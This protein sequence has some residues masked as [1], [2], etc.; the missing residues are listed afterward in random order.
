MKS[1]TFTAP[2]R[3]ISNQN[4]P[5]TFLLYIEDE[6]YDQLSQ[7]APAENFSNDKFDVLKLAPDG[8]TL[9]PDNGELEQTFGTADKGLI[10]EIM[11][12]QGQLE[13]HLDSYLGRV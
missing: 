9:P 5:S 7:G 11:V 8:N 3:G 6:T 1:V 2:S 12:K 10:S 4:S 13:G